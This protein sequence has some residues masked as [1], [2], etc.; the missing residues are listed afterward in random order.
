MLCDAGCNVTYDKNDCKVYYKNKVVWRG[1]REPSTGL[2]ILDITQTNLKTQDNKPT[3]TPTQTPKRDQINNAYHMTTKQELI[4]YLHQCL[5]C[6]PKRTLLKAIRNRQLATWPGLTIEAVEKYLP[7]SCP[8]T[9]KGHMKRQAQGIR[10]T[11]A[12][13]QASLQN[14]EYERDVNPPRTIEKDNH[15]FIALGQIDVK[16]GT[17]YADLTGNFPITAIDGSRAVFIMYDWTTNAILATPI[18]DAKTNTIVESFKKNIQYLTKRGFKPVFNIIDNVATTAVKEYLETEQIKMQLVEPHNH[19]VNAAERAIQTFKNHT[20]AGLSIV[21]EEFPSMLWSK[22]IHQAQDTLNM[23]RTSRVHPQLSAFHVLEGQHDFNRVPMAP[24]GTRGTVF[25]PPESRTSWGPRAVDAWYLSPAWDHYRC[26]KFAIPSTGGERTSGQYKLYPKHVNVPRRTPMDRAV[27]IAAN[28]TST[29]RELQDAPDQAI[30]RHSEALQKLADIFEKATTALENRHDR[31]T[32]TSSNPTAPQQ[33][34]EAPRV[35]Q[36]MTRN[37]TPGILPSPLP[38]SEGAEI[39]H[40][41]SEGGSL[42]NSS[43]GGQNVPQPENTAHRKKTLLRRSTRVLPPVSDNARN[44]RAARRQLQT[45]KENREAM[46]YEVPTPKGKGQSKRP[47]TM[48]TITQEAFQAIAL[49]TMQSAPCNRFPFTD[50]HQRSESRPDEEYHHSPGLEHFCAPVIHPTSGEII[51]SYKKLS[52]DQ[53]L[54]DVWET[55]FGKEWGGLAQGDRRTGAKGTDTFN[56]LRPDQVASIPSDRTV[57]YANIVVDY[58]EQKADPNRVRI[59]A[60]GNLITYPGEL[61]TRTA[62]ITTS[63]MLWNSVISTKGAKYMT[64]DIKNF[65]LCA[66]LDRSEFMKMPISIF[67]QHVIDQYNLMEFVYKGYIWIEIKRSI[68]GLPQA[69]KLANEYLRQKLAP[70]GYFEV[71]HTPGLWKHIT[72]PITFTLTVDDFGVKYVGK[73]HALHLLS[74]L[75]KEFESVSTDWDGVLYCGITLEWNYEEGWVDISMPGYIKKVL[76]KYNHDAPTRPQNTP[77]YIKPKQYG[78]GAQDTIPPDESPNATQEE[79]KYVQGVVGSILFYARAI[80]MTF[81]V[82]LNSIATEQ[83]A[84]TK[85]TVKSVKDLLDYAATNP[86]AKIRYW[87]SDMILQIHSDASYLSEPKSKSRASGHYFLGWQPI[88]GQPIKLNGALFTLCT[89]LKF[90]AASAAESELGAL[91][92][93]IKEG[94]VL[95][96]TLTEMGHLQPPTPIH[97]DNATAVGIANETVKKHRS[98]PMEMRYFYSCDQVKEGN[99]DVQWH[100]GLE[101]LGDYTTKH[102]DAKHHIN[103]RPI[104]LH[105]QDSPRTLPRAMKPSDL[106]GCVGNKAGGYQRGRPLPIIPRSRSHD[107]KVTRIS[108]VTRMPRIRVAPIGAESLPQHLRIAHPDKRDL[109]NNGGGISSSHNYTQLT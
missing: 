9:D 19:R 60:G 23:L 93:N 100:P 53:E 102:H 95:R 62:D 2:W 82:G 59:T 98:R 73:Q 70:H 109:V 63:K 7:A 81:L 40:P 76:H 79:I 99:F 10:S 66:P 15:I 35:H 58:R 36:R 21:D 11:K 103:V 108:Q 43:E 94:R 41:N 107:S 104:Y 55:A 13:I 38:I 86:H 64:M 90:I 83:A 6:P 26:L 101:N 33:V 31:Q 16:R 45:E 72:R 37:N 34:Q 54:K 91:F 29:L 12:K 80:D 97:C 74:I 71:K 48:H 50:C 28:L 47:K 56:I 14:I 92:L 68:Y 22:I 89:I 51:T 49:A 87:A 65:Y 96:L 52:K 44:H 1:V 25:N 88:N 39:I 78:I 5:F 17:I 61:T 75:E 32:P 42:Q 18:K 4:Q 105:T 20:I 77:Y 85:K 27:T 3:S 8:A 67:P 24:P 106:R 69:G 30:G 84:A 46:I 57:T